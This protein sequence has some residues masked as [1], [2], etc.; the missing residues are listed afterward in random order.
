MRDYE[1]EL[2]AAL[3]EG[4]LDDET[5]ARAL[6]D[7][8]PKFREEYEAQRTARAALSSVGT[9]ALTEHERLALRR[10]LWTELRAPAPAASTPWYYRWAPVAAGLFVVVGV[11]AVVNQAGSSGDTATEAAEFVV[12][13]TT[14]AATE[15]TEGGAVAGADSPDSADE[16]DGASV[17]TEALGEESGDSVPEDTTAQLSPTDEAFYAAEADR[18]REDAADAADPAD[19]VAPRSDPQA[20]LDESGLDGYSVLGTYPAPL[21]AAEGEEVPEDASPFIAAIPEGFDVEEAPIAFVDLLTC[22]LIVIDR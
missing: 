22:A 4:R 5:E 3:V 6:V 16:D 12:S 8:A 11:V 14:A 9:T 20:C 15:A 13:S 7:S 17:T 21:S 2:I 19:G 1:L 10:D 18:I